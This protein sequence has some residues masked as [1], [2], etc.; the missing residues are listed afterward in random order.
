MAIL[1]QDFCTD[2]T[3][4]EGGDRI[5]SPPKPAP[6]GTPHDFQSLY[7]QERARADAA[8]KRCEELHW[9][10]VAAR[11]DA[12]S[13]KSRF[14]SCRRRL[15]EAEE[16]TK[17]LR[18]AAK[19]VP[20]L[21]AEVARLK[22][23]LS[24]AG[25]ESSEAGKIEALH[26]EVAKL[27]RA[28]ATPRAGKDT[29]GEARRVRTALEEAQQHKDTIRTLRKELT[30]LN[31]EVVRRDK[32]IVR[33]NERL[34]QEKERTERIRETAKKL[35]QDSLRLY[36]EVGF[37][38]DAE[39]RARSLSDDV[40]W[41]R[42]A[43]DVS[44]FGQEKLKRRIAKLRA[45]GAT[46]TKLPFDEAAHL[47]NVLRRS[48]R[49]KTTIARLRR[50]NARLRKAVKVAKAGREVA[51]ARL[52]VLRT[53]RKT[54]SKKLSGM[55]AELRRVL[56]R[57]RRQKTTIKSLAGENARLRR[58]AKG[59]RN[60]IEALEAEL[61]KLR[62][63]GAVLSR[64][65]Y[66]RKSEQQKKPRSERKRGQQR[67][68]PGHGRTQRPGLEER[69]E[70]LA[71]PKDACVCAQCGQPYAPNGVE[72]STHVEIEV[73]AHKRVIQRERLRR[74]CECASSPI[75]VSAPPVPRLFR[76]TPY[77]VSV[78]AR[79]LFELCVCLRP[80]HRIAAWMTAHGLT[81]SPGTLAD[82][83]KRFVALFEPLFEAILAHQNTALVRH[84]DETSWRVQ[85]LRGEDRSNRAWLW[86]SVSDDAV[87]FHIDAS[88]SAEAAEKLFAGIVLY[89]VIVCDRYSAY[90]KL[91]RM[92][93]GLVFLAFCWAHVRRDFIDCAA[94]QPRLEQWCQGWIGRIAEIYRLND[95]RL[96]HY[97]P[98]LK[99]QTPAFDAAQTVLKGTVDILFA[100]AE[101]ELAVLSDKA[102][103]AKP[104]RSLVNHREGLC[105]FVDRP[106]V[107]L[108]NNVAER[109]LRG[110]VIGRLLSHGSDSVKGAEFTATLYS[111]VGTLSM[112]GIDALRWLEAWLTA[113]AKNGGKP[114]DDLSP[115]LPWSMSE[116]RRRKFTAPG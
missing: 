107:P 27:R 16:E 62:S 58:T 64:R 57:S 52:V 54:L 36:R 92:L 114:P 53:A 65:L 8:E 115:W 60:R 66:G 24:E 69:P 116:E 35:S 88:R 28:L 84:A 95:D 13:W 44:R 94:G 31:K 103:E 63:T 39:A 100:Q 93:G 59:L 98:G 68:A 37:L 12:G 45:A 86:T 97:D 96:E 1:D 112:N 77:G 22:T 9:A 109:I 83:L 111:V 82:S 40:F 41:L 78:W 61:A 71:P 90:K 104:L 6:A 85:E 38:R 46:L 7:E 18:R 91:A 51:E 110:P 87:C 33:L 30:R 2:L 101:R 4:V 105:V 5:W 49:Q 42:H 67:G 73:K 102:R 14:K 34:G 75:E 81:I 76:G 32:E 26:K 10:E 17:E 56:R 113:C 19:D 72:E 99:H 106:F 74:T 80:V 20:S 3:P 47:R 50:E 29:A 21:Q 23:L 48:R 55:D 25:V 70:V 108:D 11:S 79:L 15:S 89:A 43:L